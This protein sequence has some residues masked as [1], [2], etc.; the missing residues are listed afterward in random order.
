MNGAVSSETNT[1]DKVQV[2]IGASPL[3][4]SRHGSLF[5]DLGM[6]ARVHTTIINEI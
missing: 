3:T 5:C 1:D 6:A 4:G 2:L